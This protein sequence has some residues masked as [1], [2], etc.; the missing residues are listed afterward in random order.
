MPAACQQGN[1]R[2]RPVWAPGRWGAYLAVRAPPAGSLSRSRTEPPSQVVSE[3][4]APRVI[5]TI[6]EQ[7]IACRAGHVVRQVRECWVGVWVTDRDRGRRD[8]HDRTGD[9]EWGRDGGLVSG[10]AQRCWMKGTCAQPSSKGVQ[11][12]DVIRTC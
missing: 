8:R 2:R 9:S 11:K 4:F 3:C 10:T 12:C 7:S 5:T 1:R 6:G